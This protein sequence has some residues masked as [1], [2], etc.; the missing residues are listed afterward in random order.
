MQA[1]TIVLIFGQG[2]GEVFGR[3]S[4]ATRRPRAGGGPLAKTSKRAQGRARKGSAKASSVDT[5]RRRRKQ[6]SEPFRDRAKAGGEGAV[7][8][9]GQTGSVKARPSP[10]T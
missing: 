4:M 8:Q 6:T 7:D 9:I 5:E 1:I 3:S 10:F 2:F